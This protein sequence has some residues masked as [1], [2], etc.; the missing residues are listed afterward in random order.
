[1][2]NGVRLEGVKK[3]FKG[4]EV[5]K[6]CSWDCKRGEKV[7]LVG[8]NGAG[9]TTQLRIIT[10]EMEADEGEVMLADKVKIG[11]LTQEFE[12]KE[13]NT[14]R[15]EFMASFGEESKVLADTE[16]IQKALESEPSMELMTILLEKLDELQKKGRKT[17]SL[18]HGARD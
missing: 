11:Y 3:A 15:E 12:V 4:M 17:R 5:L 9:K 10:G 13:T 6:G 18:Q 1:M 8:W 16:R 14:V 7:G 2:T